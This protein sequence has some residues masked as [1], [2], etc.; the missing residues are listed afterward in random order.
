[1]KSAHDDA[2]QF[3]VQSLLMKDPILFFQWI[4]WFLTNNTAHLKEDTVRIN[5]Y[6]YIINIQII[7]F[8][9]ALEVS[10]RLILVVRAL[11]QAIRVRL[12]SMPHFLAIN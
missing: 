3:L 6:V 9:E 11:R 10:F 5:C 7:E 2:V 8:L 1:M 4:Q 12:E